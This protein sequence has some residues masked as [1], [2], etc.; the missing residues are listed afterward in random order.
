M[1]SWSY[2]NLT[3]TTVATITAIVE[4]AEGKLGETRM[5]YACEAGGV[6]RLWG[7]LVGDAARDEDVARLNALYE[8]LRTQPPD[9]PPAFRKTV[10]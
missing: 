6:Y 5:L 7:E 9:I 10:D 1:G 4:Y 3:E 2:D 8:Q